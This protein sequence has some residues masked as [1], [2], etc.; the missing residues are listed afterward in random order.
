MLKVTQNNRLLDVFIYRVLCVLCTCSEC[1]LYCLIA[2]IK[3]LIDVIH[4]KMLKYPSIVIPQNDE[5]TETK[6]SSGSRET[7]GNLTIPLLI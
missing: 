6:I 3:A 5:A 4:R 7:H 2:V 1:W